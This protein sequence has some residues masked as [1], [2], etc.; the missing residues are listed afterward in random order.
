[1]AI[2]A[3]NYDIHTRFTYRFQLPGYRNAMRDEAFRRELVKK[4]GLAK[5]ACN[6]PQVKV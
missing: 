5:V 2:T 1:V 4:P 6:P 3:G